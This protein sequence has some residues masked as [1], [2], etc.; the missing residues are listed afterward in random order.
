MR[1]SPVVLQSLPSRANVGLRN[2]FGVRCAT[3]VV[4]VTRVVQG[5]MGMARARAVDLQSGTHRSA[6]AAA[7]NVVLG[8]C[9]LEERSGWGV[10]S[11]ASCAPQQAVGA[12][13]V[14]LALCTPC[15]SLHWYDVRG[16]KIHHMLGRTR[17]SHRTGNPAL[18]PAAKDCISPVASLPPLGQ[19]K[20]VAQG[21]EGTVTKAAE[22]VTAG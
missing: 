18:L 3:W 4:K 17:P 7:K 19:P 8:V 16:R 9:A 13:A 11:Y 15:A 12:S 21:S 22:A 6:E 1:H 5:Y 2:T 10:M 14:T 20:T